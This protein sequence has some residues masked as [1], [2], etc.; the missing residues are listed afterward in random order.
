MIRSRKGMEF[1]QILGALVVLLLIAVS[2]ALIIKYIIP[3]LNAN[4]DNTDICLKDM[5]RDDQ[6]CKGAQR[7]SAMEDP[8]GICR[9]IFI[10]DS[11]G[12]DG[13]DLGQGI[14]FA[15]CQPTA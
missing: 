13:K 6:P 8:K 10:C 4:N 5:A 7:D 12:E 15:R 3:L 11:K 2:I 9:T 1:S 14:C